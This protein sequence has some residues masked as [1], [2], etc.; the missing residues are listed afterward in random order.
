MKHISFTM[1]HSHMLVRANFKLHSVLHLVR[2]YW[3]SNSSTSLLLLAVVERMTQQ[4]VPSHI[5]PVS[6]S[7]LSCG[8]LAISCH[9]AVC[10]CDYR[11]IVTTYNRN[12]QPK[13]DALLQHSLV[14]EHS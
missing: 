4:L 10:C 7:H 13:A 11:D 3:F 6:D 2:H 1:L 5:V 14:K 8:Y 9:P 12:E